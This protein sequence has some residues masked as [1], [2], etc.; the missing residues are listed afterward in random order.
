MA[1]SEAV[2]G[3]YSNREALE[4]AVQALRSAGFSAEDVAILGPETLGAHKVGTEKSTKA[5]EGAAA[6]AGTG[7]VLGGALGWLAGVGALAIPGVGPLIAAGPILGALAGAGVG[8]AVGGIA[9]ALVGTGIPEFE[10]KRYQEEISHGHIL[11]SV[12]SDTPE[13]RERAKT[14]LEET[15][16]EDISVATES[17]TS[18]AQRARAADTA[19]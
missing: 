11:L 1:K 3:I 5:P 18:A 14:I 7:L 4:R 19:H 12:H 6:G 2:F 15:G 8:S 9:G 13:E 16:A 17:R 10:A